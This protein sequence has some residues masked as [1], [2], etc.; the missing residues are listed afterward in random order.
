MDAQTYWLA[1]LLEGEGSFMKGPPS[2]PSKPVVQIQMTDEDIVA[3]AADLMGAQK[4]YAIRR[5]QAH[6]KDAWQVRVTGARAVALMRLL[7]PLMGIRRQAQIDAALESY[8]QLPRG[9]LTE[10]ERMDI[11]TRFR[12]KTSTA[13]ELAEEYKISHWNVYRL[14]ESR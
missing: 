11:V 5:Q 13:K 10:V 7:R 12:S 3:R 1:G 6:H 2:N 9:K 8:R 4:Y 14:C